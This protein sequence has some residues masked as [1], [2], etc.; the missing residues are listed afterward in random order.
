MDRWL[1]RWRGWQWADKLASALAVLGLLALI[2][3]PIVHI[4]GAKDAYHSVYFW[5]VGLTVGAPAI[6]IIF[7]SGRQTHGILRWAQWM[8]VVGL[9]AVELA[10]L[11]H[12][13]P[14]TGPL[15]FF[16]A[17]AGFLLVAVFLLVMIPYFLVTFL[18]I[19]SHLI[20]PAVSWIVA[21][22]AVLYYITF[23]PFIVF[24]AT[25]GGSTA[26]TLLNPATWAPG[27]WFRG[28]ELV[29]LLLAPGFLVLY[30]AWAHRWL[31]W[32]TTSDVTKSF[33]TRVLSAGAV[34]SNGIYV[35]MLHFHGGALSSVSLG[36]LT[37]GILFAVVLLIPYYQ[38][39]VRACWKSGIRHVID[40]DRWR[41]MLQM[42]LKEVQAG[43]VR[44]GDALDRHLPGPKEDTDDPEPPTDNTLASLE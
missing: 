36:P 22:V 38:S 4:V 44:A 24:L 6:Y 1:R 17:L 43:R 34:L 31:P 11:L 2:T 25:N 8:I 33:L 14:A 35:F 10:V 9:L 40:A 37:V 19:L 30:P 15:P 5:F 12:N 26:F 16:L 20:S 7:G 21:S 41:A 39:A 13:I 42:I 32:Q 3:L 29:F 23:P 28:T 18:R 27:G